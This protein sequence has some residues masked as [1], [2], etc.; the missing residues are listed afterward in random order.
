MMRYVTFPLTRPTLTA[1]WTL[2]F[3]LSMQE[4]SSSILLYSSRSIVLSVVVFD[5]WEVGNTNGL[6][7][8]S[9]L[10]LAVTFIAILVLIRAR[11]REV[12]S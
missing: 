9:V 10:Q 5:L 2:L 1:V 11:H 12:V 8:L 4:V 3:I 6:A 7:A